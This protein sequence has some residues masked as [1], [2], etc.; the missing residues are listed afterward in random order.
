MPPVPGND[1]PLPYRFTDL[2]AAVM[3]GRELT[4]EQMRWVM[5]DLMAG[6][7]GEAESAALLVA[8]HMRGETAEEIA[9]AAAVLREHMVRF[10]CGR[11]DVLDTCGTGGDGTGTFNIST[12]AALVAAG[13][14]VP[15]VKHGNRAI[16][17]RTGSADVL[18]ALGVSVEGDAAWAQ[19]CLDCAGLA[20]CFAPHF[21]PALRHLG[22]L[23]RRLGVR[24]LFNTLGP[25]ANPAGAGYQLLG[26]GW[27]DL[28][29]R[30]AGALARLGTRRTLL[31]CGRDGLDEVSLSAPTLVR[32][33]KGHAVSA[34]EWTPADFGL[35]ACTLEDLRVGGPDESAA[36][37]RDVLECRPGPAARVVLANAAAALMAAGRAA[38]PAEGVTLA[39]EA[40]ANGRAGQVLERL[41]AYSKGNRPLERSLSPSLSSPHRAA[42]APGG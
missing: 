40:V 42:E 1:G 3:A 34:W 21:H 18:A 12:A 10:D 14:G 26:V 30:L 33:V 29:D 24:T 8:L 38:T 35:E 17:G 9:A 13:A 23:R 15:V 27:P 41:V 16:S 2:L 20:F 7:C 31:V 37:I 22:P 6:R 28:L 19:A 25:L 32:E 39:A 5:G 11:D 36:R 4:G